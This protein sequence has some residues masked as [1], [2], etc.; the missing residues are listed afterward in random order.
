[1]CRQG[2][3]IRG[4]E[5]CLDVLGS[6]F[7]SFGLFKSQ[8]EECCTSLVQALKIMDLFSSEPN[9]DQYFTYG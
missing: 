1:M 7:M 9:F 3:I 4:T 8:F 5:K 2:F 6:D